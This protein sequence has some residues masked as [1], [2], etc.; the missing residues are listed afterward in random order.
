MSGLQDTVR[1]N[2]EESYLKAEGKFN[3]SKDQLF[4]INLE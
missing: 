1:K 2:F 3:D 4:V